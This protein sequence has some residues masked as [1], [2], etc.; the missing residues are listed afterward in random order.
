MTDDSENEKIIRYRTP[1]SNTVMDVMECRGWQKVSDN[2]P[3][4]IHWC[5]VSWLRENF[6]NSYIPKN[7]SICHF[8]NH[9]E[10][11]RKNYMVKN[12]KRLK[13]QIEKACNANNVSVVDS[14]DFFPIT[15]ELPN[16]YHLFVEEFKRERNSYEEGKIPN[17][18]TWIM[19]PVG[20]A[21]GKGIFLFRKLKD[22]QDWKRKEM[23]STYREELE[24]K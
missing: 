20:R 5:D 8:R 24:T 12:L 9:Y 3:Y 1:F 4:D 11:T 2:E 23:D 7:V 17:I 22:I 10:L 19:K 15:Y 14:V 21:Q 16:E 13:K 18:P 6:D